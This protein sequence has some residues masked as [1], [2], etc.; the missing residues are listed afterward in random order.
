M[1]IF[2]EL[3]QDLPREGP[4]DNASTLKALS[5]M[6]D[7]PP[8]P[9]ILDI[10]C[11]PGAQTLELAKHTEGHITAID[12][13]QPFLD[14]LSRNAAAGRLSN[15]ITT[16]NMSMFTLDLPPH[17]F[18]AIWSEGAI[19]IMG[20]E[21]GLRACRSL[22]KPHGYVAVTEISWL[23]PDPPAEAHAFWAENYSGMG[24]VREN[25]DHVRAAGYREVAHFVLPTSSWWD[26]YYTPQEARIA[27]LR[28]KYRDDAEAILLL[29]ET[30]REIDLY[31][32]Y[33]DWYGYVFYVM[34]AL[35]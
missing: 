15:R 3:H 24:N 27:M 31:R 1:N 19:Y 33:S 10:G 13:H 23:R 18:D 29:D 21:P 17:S 4:G 7:L 16:V 30:Q 2:F 28:K 35:Q 32:R 11:G 25:L 9:A 34:Q 6:A 8:R 14:R 12:T 22:L 5:C 20:F 26:N